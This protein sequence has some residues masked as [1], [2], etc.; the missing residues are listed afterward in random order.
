VAHLTQQDVAYLR[1]LITAYSGL[2]E[3]LQ[4]VEALERAV[5]QRLAAHKLGTMADYWP[6]LHRRLSAEMNSLVQLLTNKETFF[7]REMH[8]FEVLRDRILPEL[9]AAHKFQARPGYLRGLSG[10]E[11]R[12]PLRLWSAGCSTGEEAYSLAITLLEYKKRYPLLDAEIVATD[13]D[14]DAIEMAQRGQYGERAIRLVPVDLLQRY[15]TSNGRTFQIASEVTRLVRFQVHNLAEEC[16]PH[17]L[18]GLDVVFCRNVTIYFDREARDQLNARLADSLREGGYLFVASA[19]TMSHNR[20]RLELFPVGNTFL[21]RKHL[22]ASESIPSLADASYVAWQPDTPSPPRIATRPTRSSQRIEQPQPRNGTSV[23]AAPDT[24]LQQAHTAFQ[25]QEYDVTLHELDRIPADQ[26]ALLEAYSL[27]AAALLQQDRLVE[28]E[29]ACQYL[30]AHDPWH[31]DA[32]FLMGLI[33]YHQGQAKAAIQSFKTAV[34][35]QPEHRWAHF[36]LAET[37]RA[38]G[39]QDSAYREYRNTLNTLHA[40]HRSRQIP[41]LNLTGLA[42]DVLRQACETNLGRLQRR[43]VRER[44]GRYRA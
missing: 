29:S 37:Y 35:L 21:F 3:S 2:G 13:I 27:R 44:A 22:S 10:S 32:H 7:F 41:E 24:L 17:G 1:D 9:V 19:E 15:F 6:F 38:L 16:C 40:A 36:Y 43:S 25:R 33:Y 14:A 39:W 12:Q 42:D 30:L 23:P 8:Q 34:Y 5:A 28:A 11:K 18:S 31:T 26:P 20:G 4:T